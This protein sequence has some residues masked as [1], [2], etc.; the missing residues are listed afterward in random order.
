MF[1]I[2]FFLTYV[3][4]KLGNFSVNRK[5]IRI[6]YVVINGNSIF[7]VSPHEQFFMERMMFINKGIG[8]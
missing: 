8:L 1:M 6:V 5:I 7:D 4:G 3:G 2:L